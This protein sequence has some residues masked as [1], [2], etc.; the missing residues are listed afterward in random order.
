MTVIEPHHLSFVDPESSSE[1]IVFNVTVPVPP[2]QGKRCH[3]SSFYFFIY[4][5]FFTKS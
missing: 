1:K 5:N 4:F 2:N 3:C